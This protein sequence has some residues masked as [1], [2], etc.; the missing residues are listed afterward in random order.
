MIHFKDELFNRLQ[1]WN[2]F[3]QDAKV[4]EGELRSLKDAGVT[5]ID[6]NYVST[7][8]EINGN[9]LTEASKYTD[10]Q[11]NKELAADIQLATDAKDTKLELQ[12][13]PE[14]FTIDPATELLPQLKGTGL[15]YDSL[16]AYNLDPEFKALAQEM[17]TNMPRVAT[18]FDSFIEQYSGYSAYVNELQE[19]Y[20]I[21]NFEMQEVDKQAWIVEHFQAENQYTT[22]IN[23]YYN[24]NLNNG[25]VPT[26]SITKNST[27]ALK[28]QTLTDTLQSTFAIE[29]VYQDVFSDTHYDLDTQSFIVDD[30]N[31]LESKLAEYFNSDTNTIDEKLYLAKVMHLQ[32]GGLEFEID[33]ILKS[34]NNDITKELARY[35]FTGENATLFE[36]KE[37][38]TTKGVIVT[39]GKDE[40]ITTSDAGNKIL[41]NGGDDK[42]I[43]G[44]GNDT[45]YFRKGDGADT[46]F[47]KG[48]VDIL[49]FDEAITR[50]SVELKLNRNSDLIIA[51][52]EDGKTFDELSDKVIMVDWMKSSNRVE[53]IKFGDGTTLKFQDVFELFEAT[54]GV[55]VIQLSSGNDIIDTKD[56]NDVIVA[57]GGNDT[58]IGDK[59][60]DRL[61]GGLGNDTYIY[62]RGDG[63]DTIIDSGGHDT[64]QFREGISQDDLWH[65][66]A[67]NKEFNLKMK[68]G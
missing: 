4:Q 56:G 24:S 16:I 65:V 61:E 12:D 2:D 68:V 54:D 59:G 50:E 37:S 23:N 10:A 55:E 27:I 7:N 22:T 38:Y 9:L 67:N 44:K 5:S 29:S 52:K 26:N 39:S 11:G 58:L 25:R 62:A 1:V 31:A 15:V 13:L 51:F 63:K 20:S 35:I 8:I 17:S 49:V 40:I 30:K 46:I 48:G 43:S 57:L 3:N 42:L 19:K 66:T 33:T 32:Q 18:E 36:N 6:L 34:I 47:D 64:L 14:D 53:L 21:E 41:L 45:F 28:Y 60:D